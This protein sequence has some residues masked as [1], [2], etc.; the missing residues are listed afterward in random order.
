MALEDLNPAVRVEEILDGA[1][2]E[3]ATRLEYF[4]KKAANEVPK[5]A[6]SSDAGKV[7]TVNEDGDGYE[8]GAIPSGLPSYTSA[9]K[10]KV[11]TI[12]EGEGSVT[13]VIVPEQTVNLVDGAASL[14]NVAITYDDL[15][16]GDTATL[17]ISDGVQ[18]LEYEMTVAEDS[19]GESTFLY[20]QYE[21][22]TEYYQILYHPQNG[23]LIFAQGIEH[24]PLSGEYTVSLVKT[25]PSVE[26]KWDN[27]FPPLPTANGNYILTI[28]NGTASWTNQS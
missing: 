20:Y 5:P 10:G 4:M 3:P 7:V 13:T 22:D 23:W 16:V 2:I 8:L 6:G 19:E 9:D 21:S 12:G 24:T 26:P 11:L 17:H 18:S 27:V 28:S 14:S 15:V 1:D 25:V